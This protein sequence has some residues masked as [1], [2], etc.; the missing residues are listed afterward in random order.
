MTATQLPPSNLSTSTSGLVLSRGPSGLEIF[1]TIQ[2][3]GPLVGKNTTFMR[4]GGCN[5]TCSWCDTPYTWDWKGKNGTP[6]AIRDEVVTLPLVQVMRELV[7]FGCKNLVITG[8]EPLIQW[9]RLDQLFTLFY[10]TY[11]VENIFFDIIQFETNGT[12]MPNWSNQARWACSTEFRYVVSPKLLNSGNPSSTR[13]LNQFSESGHAWFKFVCNDITDFSEVMAIQSSADIP[14]NLIYIMAQGTDPTV[15][16]EKERAMV[17]EVIQRGW[18]LTP[19]F[20]QDL[21]GNTRAR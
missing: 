19:R 4:L 5:L 6:Y 1:R 11:G 16:H 17:D 3:E 8:G 13:Y 9:E 12:V 14:N 2:G 21:W 7:K 10:G 15:I 18:N 20:H